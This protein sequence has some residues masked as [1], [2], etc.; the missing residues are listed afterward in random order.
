M[1]QLANETEKVTI[2]LSVVELAQI[3][4]L[5]E[6]GLYSNRTDFIRTGLR[7]ELDTNKATIE[8]ALQPITDSEDQKIMVLGITRVH[9]NDLLELEK[10]GQKLDISVIGMLVIANEIST[11]LFKATVARLKCR[12]KLVASDAIKALVVTD[13]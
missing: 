6:Q 1:G 3:D 7:K 13:Y 4:V 2:N 5:V 11:Q 10:K 9:K 8:R 12:G